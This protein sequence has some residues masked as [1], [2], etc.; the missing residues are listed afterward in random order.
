MEF[1]VTIFDRWGEEVYESYNTDDGWDGNYLGH[2]CSPGYY[3]YRIIAS[4]TKGQKKNM[5]GMLLLLH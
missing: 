2:K 3:Y 1:H 4:G 5:D